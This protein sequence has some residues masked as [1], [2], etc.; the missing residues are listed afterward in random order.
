M[1]SLIDSNDQYILA[2]ATRT[3]NLKNSEPQRPEDRV[4]LGN[5]VI[6][7]QDG[8]DAHTFSSTYVAR[9][10]DGSAYS[11]EALVVPDTRED[12]RF[13]DRPYVRNSH[14][15]MYAGVPIKTRS[16]HR[17]GVYGI[18]DDRP[19][20]QGLSAEDIVFL[21]DL[22]ATVMEHLEMA[23]D[24]H[25]RYRGEKMVRGL[26]EFIEG[27]T[28]PHSPHVETHHHLRQSHSSRT[29]EKQT[30]NAK[31][32]DC[33][34]VNNRP[35]GSI[36][37]TVLPPMSPSSTITDAQPTGENDEIAQ[38]FP[39]AAEI[40][41][42]STQADGI[43]FFGA[44]SGTM[45]AK[46]PIPT[47]A[48]GEHRPA[49]DES[50]ASSSDHLSGGS[51]GRRRSRT[52]SGNSTDARKNA[53]IAVD[54]DEARVR[55]CEV[56]ALSLD[57][58]LAEESNIVPEDFAFSEQS[59]ERYVRR[60]PHGKFFAFTERGSG[61]SSGDESIDDSKRST[62]TEES[63]TVEVTVPKNIVKRAKKRKDGFIP[64]ELLKV[65]PGIRSLIFLPLWDYTEEVFVAGAF[66]WTSTAGRLMSPS[67][68]LPY[69]KAFGN[70]I[71]NEIAFL[72]AQKADR[73]K[74]T[75]I[76]SV[77]HELRSPLHG[78]LGGVEFLMDT[79]LNEYQRGLLNS[80]ETCSKTLLDTIDHVLDYAKINK[81]R[82]VS[83]Q[84]KNRKEVNS[85][86]KSQLDDSS[87]MGLS[88]EFDLATLIEESTDAVCAGHA[89]KR[90]HS[91]TPGVELVLDTDV[92]ILLSIDPKA[93]RTVRSQPGAIRRIVMNV[94]GKG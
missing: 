46:I 22:A 24:K 78:I 52:D 70:S 47:T 2:E 61:V 48:T 86:R 43:V 38:V 69:L 76:A 36:A 81:L 17:I 41:R 19:H 84:G 59:M 44:L 30:E 55:M 27:T 5:S 54:S 15:L 9:R 83:T 25:D 50:Q 39:R 49:S 42:R 29:L 58:A 73:A 11:T 63:A 4:W 26:A 16:G 82:S 23:K 18:S 31:L 74:A 10:D 34:A 20:P 80:V 66:I 6:A 45:R 37:D 87:I 91:G 57:Q 13:K 3:L 8:I 35:V 75:F 92:A 79:P 65:L 60:Y 56:L 62:Q 33:H 1:I 85:K 7:R 90:K 32:D 89:S 72:N 88:S 51:A 53:G 77:S 28:E 21:E 67:N 40:I 94:L 71:M 14:V 68:E 12:T 93:K 64:T